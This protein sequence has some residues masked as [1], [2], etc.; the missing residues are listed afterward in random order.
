M[1]AQFSEIPPLD[2]VKTLFTTATGCNFILEVE[3]KS[4]LDID[5]DD[6]FEFMPYIRPCHQKLLMDTANGEQ[7]SPCA[8]LRQLLR[9][10]GYTIHHGRI[11]YSLQEIKEGSKT[12]DK[13]VGKT[14]TW[15]G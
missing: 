15:M 1:H 10:H 6:L 4:W 7:K 5:P 8:F 14:V 12:V 2:E 11:N 3:W 13:K 9:P